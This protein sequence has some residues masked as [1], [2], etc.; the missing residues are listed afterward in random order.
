MGNDLYGKHS[1]FFV[2]H[3]Q[4]TARTWQSEALDTTF[5][6]KV[7][8][9]ECVWCKNIR[10]LRCK[11]AASVP[12]SSEFH[13]ASQRL[14]TGS[15]KACWRRFWKPESRSELRAGNTVA[16]RAL[17]SPRSG[18]K[19]FLAFYSVCQTHPRAPAGRSGFVLAAAASKK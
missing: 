18:E 10:K 15:S 17:L 4:S 9:V 12:N 2:P 19:I 11:L 1:T 3:F 5:R 14:K 13:W 6:Q 7:E 16:K 8:L